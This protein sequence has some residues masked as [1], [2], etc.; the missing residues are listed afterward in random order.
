MF[1][2]LG[3]VA[4]GLREKD[5]S[6]ATGLLIGLI[7]WTLTHLVDSVT[8]NGTIE[9]ATAYTNATL[10]DGTHVY[11]IEVDVSNLSS[12]TPIPDLEVS[13]QNPGPDNQATFYPAET[14]CK[15]QPPSWVGSA[16]CDS[17]DDGGD[18]MVPLLVPGTSVSMAMKYLGSIEPAARPIVRIRPGTVSNFRL[19]T[20]GP[21]TFITRYETDLLLGILLLAV[22]LFVI[23]V[24]G[25]APSDEEPGSKE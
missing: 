2:W 5:Q 6:I 17:H 14:S 13:I 18:L 9:Y 3:R 15:F 21:A 7:I 24:T 23:S 8:S 1:R 12:D 19:I 25:G 22:L 20:P 10:K 11:Q 4:R 16:L